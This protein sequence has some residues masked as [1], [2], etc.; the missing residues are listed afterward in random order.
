MLK[1]LYGNQRTARTQVELNAILDSHERFAASRGGT[2]AQLGMADLSGL[3]LANRILKEI[4][5]AGSSLMDAAL[6]GSNFERASFYCCDL[7]RADFKR[8]GVLGDWEHPYRTMDFRYEADMIRALAKI[9]ANGHVVRGFKPVYWCFDCGSALAEAEIEYQDKQSPAID[10]AYDAIDPKALAAKFG[11]TIGDDDIVAV[12]IWTAEAPTAKNSRTSC[13][14]MMPPIPM[15][16]RLTARR[17]SQTQRRA[18]GLTAGPLRPPR[19]RLGERRPAFNCG[20][21]A[22]PVTVLMAE[23]TSAPPDSAALASSRAGTAA[24]R[25]SSSSPRACRCSRSRATDRP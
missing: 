7:Q 23:S 12:P 17:I 10:V 16:G 2:R 5:F 11:A 22:R 25:A 19:I 1:N 8:L 15:T 3:N 20:V 9:H 21:T 24:A 18:I 4:D 6:S 14:H 13:R